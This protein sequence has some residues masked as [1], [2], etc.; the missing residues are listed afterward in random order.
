M[1]FK[2]SFIE[3]IELI[4][5]NDK[6]NKYAK[7]YLDN[8]EHLKYDELSYYIYSKIKNTDIIEDYDYFIK[9]L[10]DNKE[11]KIIPGFTVDYFNNSNDQIKQKLFSFLGIV[12]IDNFE[13]D[14]D[15]SEISINDMEKKIDENNE[16]IDKEI[17]KNKN[18]PDTDNM[19]D[20]VLNMV[21]TTG[22]NEKIQN[23]TTEDLDKMGEQVNKI[24]GNNESSK[25]IG[26]MVQTIG[27]EL[28]NEKLGTGKLS[29]QIKTIADK[30]S[31]NYVNGDKDVSEKDVDNLYET[32][33]NF[34]NNFQNQNL[35]INTINKVLKEYGI[36]QTI[37]QN[38]LNKAC[39][40][41]GITPQQ[42]TNPNRKLKR[43]MQQVQK[44]PI[45]TNPHNK[46]QQHQ[47]VKYQTKRK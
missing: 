45:K 37:T 33:Q 47:Q 23:L 21:D 3:L 11:I 31:D 10:N 19:M 2:K 38:D 36:N 5:N 25:L 8:S 18:Q 30:V 27:K 22:L 24:L 46:K 26:D 42:L 16:E 14:D 29:D 12:N 13:I 20:A 35:D 39:Q 4:L 9:Y 40:Y 1:D 17:E 41:M 15:Y 28:K 6:D 44:Q 34:V 32:A 43:K 7:K